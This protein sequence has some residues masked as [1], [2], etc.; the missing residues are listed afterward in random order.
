[1]GHSIQRA[2]CVLALTLTLAACSDERCDDARCPADAGVVLLDLGPSDIGADAPRDDGDDDVPVSIDV[3][4]ADRVSAGDVADVVDVDD[5]ADVPAPTDVGPDVPAGFVACAVD[6]GVSVVDPQSDP[7]HCGACGT[8]C[9]GGWCI[10]GRCGT[11][12]PPGT[13]GCPLPPAEEAARGC[14][15]PVPVNGGFDPANCG[16]CGVRCASDEVCRGGTCARVDAGAGAD[17]VDAA[18]EDR[19]D[20]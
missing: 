2:V 20:A 13:I 12:G 9:C 6:G 10:N 18:T 7:Q 5:V 1:M 17:V 3:P 8:R 4:A 11:E 19:P 14:T 15:G 16:G